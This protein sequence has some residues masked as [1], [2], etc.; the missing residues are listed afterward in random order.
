MVTVKDGDVL[1]HALIGFQAE[2]ER[3]DTKIEEL[4][5]QLNEAGPNGTLQMPGPRRPPRR[6]RRSMSPAARRRISEAQKKRWAAYHRREG[7]A[8]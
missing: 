8:A 1:A 3:L 5:A 6:A 4:W 7:E 2:R